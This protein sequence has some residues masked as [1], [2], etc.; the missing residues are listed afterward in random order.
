VDLPNP[1][2]LKALLKVCRDYGVSDVSFGSISVK[3]GDMPGSV[4]DQT[5]E[6]SSGPTDE[7]LAYWSSHDPMLDIAGAQ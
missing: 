2:E 4:Q 3:F 1:K 5:V 7:Q 6:Q